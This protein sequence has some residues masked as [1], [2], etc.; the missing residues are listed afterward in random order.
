MARR[1][2]TSF[3]STSLGRPEGHAPP[4]VTADTLLLSTEG[5]TAPGDPRNCGPALGFGL[6]VS[7]HLP[8][9]AE[10]CG[11]GGGLA[12]RGCGAAGRGDAAVSPVNRRRCGCAEQVAVLCTETHGR[13]RPRHGRARAG[14]SL[15]ASD[16]ET[17]GAG[18]AAAVLGGQRG[19][20]GLPSQGGEGLRNGRSP[21]DSQLR[22]RDV[23]ESEP[24]GGEEEASTEAHPH[25]GMT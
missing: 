20:E 9:R 24:D 23:S 19:S 10:Q 21:C 11:L 5:A 25:A 3:L 13:P 22:L 1:A 4:A 17:F 6:D 7:P 2:W 16:P 15:I 12:L 18:R 14:E 8:R